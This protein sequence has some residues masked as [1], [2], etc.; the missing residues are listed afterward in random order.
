M[1]AE[2]VAV[3]GAHLEI[4]PLEEALLAASEVV[5]LAAVEQEEAGKLSLFLVILGGTR[6]LE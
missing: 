6:P 3:E 1:V 5:P 4:S 2:E